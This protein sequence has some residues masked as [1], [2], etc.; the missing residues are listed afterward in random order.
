MI[1]IIALYKAYD[2]E[3]FLEAS[4]KSIYN[5]VEKIVIVN[6]RISWQGKK[7]N[8]IEAVFK[9]INDRFNKITILNFDSKN[10]SQQ[11]VHGFNYIK[12][13]D[14][15][16]VLIIDADE[17]WPRKQIEKAICCLNNAPA[18]KCEMITHIKE[19][20]YIVT[21]R[22]NCRPCVFIKKG[23]LFVGVRGNRIKG[24]V[25]FKPDIYFHHFTLVR[26][27]IDKIKEKIVSSNLGDGQK[28]VDVKGWISSV[29]DNI[30]NVKDFHI[31][32]KFKTSWKGIT[33]IELSEEMKGF[34][35]AG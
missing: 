35:Y 22:E 27:S 25:K 14:Y 6:S 18:Y 21:P 11:Y 1:K 23:V 16:Y 4:I 34:L 33:R 26:N 13:L 24:I 19:V 31:S 7:E 20:N 28:P 3:E 2:G 12:Q 15:D 5:Y 8:T 32:E 9:D 30:P 17:V 10:Q 29:W